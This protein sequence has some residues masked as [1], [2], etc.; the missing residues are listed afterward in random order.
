MKNKGIIL[1]LCIFFV[2]FSACAIIGFI[3]YEDDEIVDIEPPKDEIVYE[4]YIEDALSD[5]LPSKDDYIF[6]KFICTNNIKAEFDEEKWE[7]IPEINKKATCQ[8]YFVKK[9]YE[10]TVTVSNGIVNE[11]NNTKTVNREDSITYNITPNEGYMFGSAS[12]SDNKDVKWDS[13]T[14]T[15]TIDS[16]TKDVACKLVFSVTKLKF[17]IMVD[18]ESGTGSDEETYNYGDSITAVVKPKSG[19]EGTEP[20][21]T[22]SN[23]QIATYDVSKYILSIDKLTNDTK[24]SIKFKKTPVKVF[25]FKLIL[26]DGISISTGGDLVTGIKVSE[27]S[28]ENFTLRVENGKKPNIDCNGKLASSINKVDDNNYSFEYLDITSDMTC[29]V[30]N[31]E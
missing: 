20:Q 21:I 18:T 22:C 10:T 31:G 17:T 14:N 30:S 13:S 27:G 23:N 25:T 9:V 2:L 5:K 16:V 4:Y 11:E 29:K 3:N 1:I 12:C 7:F 15:L 6:S 28:S 19:Y 8:L 26:E 24:C